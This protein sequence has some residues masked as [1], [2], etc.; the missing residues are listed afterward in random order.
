MIISLLVIHEWQT[1]FIRRG[2][3]SCNVEHSWPITSL[4]SCSNQQ[5]K[6]SAAQM[7][8]MP[9]RLCFFIHCSKRCCGRDRNVSLGSFWNCFFTSSFKR[10][11]VRTAGFGACV[12]TN[13]NLW[14]SKA[15]C[16]ENGAGVNFFSGLSAPVL[17][18]VTMLA[19]FNLESVVLY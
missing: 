12:R 5:R 16:T 9:F 11:R 19:L 4:L 14:F 10:V 2:P 18:L 3:L 1:I 17:N 6:T 7:L 13:K 8:C 15:V